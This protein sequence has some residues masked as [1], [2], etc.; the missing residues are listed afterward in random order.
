MTPTGNKEIPYCKSHGQKYQQNAIDQ[1]PL[2]ASSNLSQYPST[3]S[4]LPSDYSYNAH[5]HVP[6]QR[7]S[8]TSSN[9]PNTHQLRL[10]FLLITLIAHTLNTSY[11]QHMSHN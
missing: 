3:S 4:F 7:P 1:K 2:T 11:V 8:T 6:D 5:T 10:F 9:I